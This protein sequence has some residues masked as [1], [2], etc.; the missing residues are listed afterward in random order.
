MADIFLIEAHHGAEFPSVLWRKTVGGMLRLLCT[1]GP[2]GA[3]VANNGVFTSKQVDIC[4]HLQKLKGSKVQK[5]TVTRSGS[6]LDL[7]TS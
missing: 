2:V 4:K 1:V 5:E 7:L 3:V 6:I